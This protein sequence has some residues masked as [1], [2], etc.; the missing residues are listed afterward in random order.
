MQDALIAT[1]A[2]ASAEDREQERI[3][4]RVRQKADLY[5]HLVAFLVVGGILAGLDLLTSPGTLWFFW[6]MG[7]WAIGLVLHFADVYVIGEDAGMEAR[8][9]R[10]EM[11]RHRHA[12]R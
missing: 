2:P 3:R 10:R 6:P 8:M 4:R 12:H 7:F 11:E 5:R 1:A 9:M